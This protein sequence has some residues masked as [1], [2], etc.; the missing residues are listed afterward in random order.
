MVSSE[1]RV[2]REGQDRERGVRG[3]NYEW[4]KINKIQ[5]RRAQHKQ[6]HQYSI[7]T[8]S[9]VSA[10]KEKASP[11]MLTLST[12]SLKARKRYSV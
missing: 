1:K 9:G 12:S 5:R 7:T 6:Y 2:G 4:C 8:L 3:T 11:S 10:I